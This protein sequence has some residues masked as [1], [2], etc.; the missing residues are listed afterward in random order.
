MKI[1]NTLIIFVCSALF[2]GCGSNSS[3]TDKTKDKTTDNIS[4]QKVEAEIPLNPLKECYF[5]DLHLHTA[6]SP[7]AT[8]IGASLFP[9][10]AYKFAMGEEVTYMGQKVKRIAP[11][12]F[13]GV[14]DHSEYLGAMVA[15]KDPNGPYVGTELYEQA[16]STDKK[17]LDGAFFDWVN[18]MTTNTPRAE[19]N[20]EEVMKSAWQR[21]IEAANT[22]YKPG[23]FTT[24]VGY[25]WTSAPA[26]ATG[27]WLNIH[28]C[29]IFKGD[30]VP[31][32]PFTSFDSQDPEELWTYLE[33]ARKTGDDVIAIPHNGNVSNGLMFDTKTLTGKPLTKE[34]A[35]RRILNEP[36]TEISQGKGTS[37]THPS[38]SPN[39]E[40]ANFELWEKL[41][42][43]H[44]TPANVETGSYVRQA[45]GVGQEIQ[46][47]IGA[48]PFKFGIEASTDYHS[49]M[50]SNEE[51]NYPGSHA[52]QDDQINNYKSLL[53][54]SGGIIGEPEV[55][56]GASGLT[57]V[58]AES[59]TRDAIFESLKRK[60]CFGTSGVRIK[61]RMFASWDYTA[62]ILNQDDWVKQAY[63]KG[64]PM[65]A[66]LPNTNINGK[67]KFLVQAIKDPNSGNLDRLQIVKVSTKNGK[68]TE[69]IY[70]VIW[71]GDRTK[72][73]DG[74]LTPVGNTVDIKT[75]SYTNTIGV[76]E[77]IGYWEDKDFDPEAYVTY[78][79]RVLEIPTPRWSTYLAAKHNMPVSSQVSPTIQER[80]WT[81]PVWY[82]PAK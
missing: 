20:N 64:V 48:N 14:T 1:L 50:S 75:A 18:D 57:G 3:N 60:E 9:E 53:E 29:V 21:E 68:S 5:G 49:A 36:I 40:F 10:D 61:V 32:L 74:N 46:A 24:F 16:N 13:L 23:K 54:S 27:D 4:S 72:D 31:M 80:A 56:F 26:S 33:N 25:E 58:W 82:V 42:G 62:E 34:Y 71:S 45:Y 76:A 8:L 81:S 38:L 22:F 69:N 65:G 77:L 47:Q 79:V 15:L 43:V 2:V 12:D 66:D 70:N 28:R 11:L 35:D 73:A 63:D 44:G 55:K 41:L 7:D 30:K 52:I 6:L 39:D 19:L 51:N 37:E 17:V 59:N 78:Y 67:P